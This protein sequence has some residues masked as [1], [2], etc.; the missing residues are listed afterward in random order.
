MGENVLS[1]ITLG[2]VI[3]TAIVQIVALISKHDTQVISDARRDAKL[4]TILEKMEGMATL[5]KAVH[6]HEERL[7]KSEQNQ[8]QIAIKLNDL[9]EEHKINTK[10][11]NLR[12]GGIANV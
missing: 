12:C 6:N 3:L 2:A 9:C 11:L 8:E 1:A 5:E 4:D 7:F 10:P